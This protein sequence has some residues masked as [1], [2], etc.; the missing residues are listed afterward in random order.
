MVICAWLLSLSIM[1]S[2]FF[3]TVSCIR[4]SFLLGPNNIPVYVYIF[5][6][7]LLVIMNN[8]AVSIFIQG[9]LY[10]HALSLLLGIYLRREFLGYL[11]LTFWATARL[12]PWVTAQFDIPTNSVW[13]F[14][15][16][17]SSSICVIVC[18]FYSPHSRKCEV[19]LH[20]DFDLHFPAD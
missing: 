15:F 20:C 12:F 3:H 14:D 18:L 16:S 9:F 2:S 8:A 17:T 11:C 1:C 6:L 4:T 10:G 7:H 13:R 19:V 5:Y